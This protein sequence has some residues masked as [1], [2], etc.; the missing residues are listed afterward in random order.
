MVPYSITHHDTMTGKILDFPIT[1]KPFPKLILYDI[2]ITR[3]PIDLRC[4]YARNDISRHNSL[5]VL[6]IISI[7]VSI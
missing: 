2:I 4:L 5:T 7:A 6:I 3:N 1:L